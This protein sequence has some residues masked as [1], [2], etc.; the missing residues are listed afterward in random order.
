MLTLLA[1]ECRFVSTID[2]KNDKILCEKQYRVISR[3]KLCFVPD[4]YLASFGV[5]KTHDLSHIVLTMTFLVYYFH[6]GTYDGGLTL[7]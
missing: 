1:R 4:I 6:K 2:I 5:T 7:F 3:E